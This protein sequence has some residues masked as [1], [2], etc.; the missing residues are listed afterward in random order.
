MVIECIG[1]EKQKLV[2]SQGHYVLSS[3]QSSM[4]PATYVLIALGIIAI[5][6]SIVLPLTLIKKKED[7]P[8]V[9]AIKNASCSTGADFMKSSYNI[10]MTCTNADMATQEAKDAAADFQARCNNIDVSNFCDT[11]WDGIS[12]GDCNTGYANYIA[13]LCT[14]KTLSSKCDV[15]STYDGASDFAKYLC[16]QQLLTATCT[17]LNDFLRNNYAIDVGGP[18]EPYTSSQSSRFDADLD[19][20]QHYYQ[21]TQCGNFLS[22]NQ[23]SAQCA[24]IFDNLTSSDCNSPGE[25]LDSLVDYAEKS[26]SK[27]KMC[28]STQATDAVTNCQA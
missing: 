15:S 2:R 11:A 21:T 18:C 19:A 26:N 12:E 17:D 7:S 3:Y 16:R 23:S 6:L 13:N 28:S 1:M 4:Q 22:S 5:V 8:C 25:G 24:G 27:Y 10:T 14:G 9:A 20:L